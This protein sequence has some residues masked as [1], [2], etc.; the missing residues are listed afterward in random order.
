MISPQGYTYGE[1]PKADNPFWSDDEVVDQITATASV[2]DTSGTPAVTV[3]KSNYNF[4][5]SFT[6]LKGEQGE[7]GIQGEPG[8]TG[9]TGPQGEQG[10]AGPQGETGATGATG[11]QG[12]AGEDGQSPAVVSTGATGSGEA[13][14]TITGADGTVITVYNGAQGE[15]GPQGEKGETGATGAQGPQGEQGPAG[16]DADISTCVTNVSVTNTDGVY[17]IKQTIDGTESE[18]GQINVPNIDNLLA[19]VTDS[20]VEN[21]TSGYDYH[22]VKETENNGA[23]NDVGSFY[24]ARNQITALNSD[25]SFT[26]VDQ[27]GI[28]G[29]GSISLPGELKSGFFSGSITRSLSTTSNLKLSLNLLKYRIYSSTLGGYTDYSTY[30]DSIYLG[31]MINGEFVAYCTQPFTYS[32]NYTGT[33]GTVTSVSGTGF[34]V[35]QPSGMSYWSGSTLVNFSF[36]LFTNN[37]L[38]DSIDVDTTSSNISVTVI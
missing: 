9:E 11:P 6:G 13:A 30:G 36:Y 2:D 33:D 5:F 38:F 15:Q 24:L 4:N 22:T 8:A 31:Y 18:V 7:Q 27:S 16:S 19:E 35:P 25:G 20:V 12:P 26:T 10:P 21:T 23:Q 3:T 1:D 29:T 37:K 17:D 32:C 14:G 34:I 28:E